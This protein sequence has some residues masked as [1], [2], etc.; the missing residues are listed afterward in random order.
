MERQKLLINKKNNKYRNPFKNI[1]DEEFNRLPHIHKDSNEVKNKNMEHAVKCN[2]DSYD[3]EHKDKIDS[4]NNDFKDMKTE[5]NNDIPK[6][7]WLTDGYIQTRIHKRSRREL[8]TPLRIAS[9][10]PARSLFTCRITTG[11]YDEDGSRFQ[12]VD[13][14]TNRST[15]HRALS[16][17]WTGKTEFIL[18]QTGFAERDVAVQPITAGS[19]TADVAPV[20]GSQHI[21][22]SYMSLSSNLQ[23]VQL[24]VSSLYMCVY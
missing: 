3:N 24:P 4:D 5:K 21:E 10:P 15:A 14:W 16:R 12:V 6:D 23:S 9:S 2:Y 19:F 1:T 20:R 7:I 8:F 17:P 18:K 22:S 11:R 13:S